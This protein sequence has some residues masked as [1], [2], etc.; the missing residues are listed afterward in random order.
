MPR[1][2]FTY[3]NQDV[4]VVWKPQMCIHS[5]ICWTNLRE[6]FDPTQRPWINMDGSTTQKIIQ[7]VSQCPSGALSYQTNAANQTPTAT[8]ATPTLNIQ[9]ATDGPILI[10]TECTIQHSNGTTETKTGT[11]ALCRCGASSNKPYC[12]GSH[13]KMDFKG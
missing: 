3:N 4:T 12:D 5:K 9:I 1:E 8:E 2:T 10:K 6:V 11:T 7:Q 13:K